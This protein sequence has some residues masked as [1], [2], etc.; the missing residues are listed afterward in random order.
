MTK[1]IVKDKVRGILNNYLQMNN[2]R[3]T[4]ERFAILDAVYD[5]KGHFSLDE[6][7]ETMESQN[8]RVS[9]ATL[10]NT[11]RLFIELRLVVRHRFI[12]QT[13]YEACYNNED[14]IHQ[15]CTVCGAVTEIESE[16]ITNLI[17]DTKLQRFRKDG[18]SLYIYG[19]CSRCQ[20]KISRERN[21]LK[22]KKQDNR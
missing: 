10:Y 1:D 21:K 4:S 2:H 13:K 5:M 3:K 17:A 16:A 19:V 9:R 11:M 20:T 18:F 22:T 12:G 8:F 14:H 15:I 7:G 6:L